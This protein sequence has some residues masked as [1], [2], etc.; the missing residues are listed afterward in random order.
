MKKIFS[1]PH[2]IPWFLFIFFTA[3]Y[4]SSTVGIMNSGDGPEYALTQALVEQHTTKID[5]FDRW[6]WPDYAEINGHKFI[7]RPPGI[8]FI[9]VPFY[10]LA[11]T[12]E[13][14]AFAPYNGSAPGIDTTSKIEALTMI[15]PALGASLTVVLLYL[16]CYQFTKDSKPSFTASVIFGLGTL[17]WKYSYSFIRQPIYIFLLILIYYL[18]SKLKN[19]QYP[20]WVYSLIGLLTGYSLLVETTTLFTLPIFFLVFIFIH[21]TKLRTAFERFIVLAEFLLGFFL[22]LSLLAAYNL[23]SYDQISRNLYQD[24]ERSKWMNY[25]SLFSTPL[26]PSILIN[27]F[28]NAPIPKHALSPILRSNEQ[29]FLQESA[30]WATR[31]PYKGLFFQSPFLFLATLGFVGFFRKYK[32]WALIAVSL[33]LSILIPL[34]KYVDF[35]SPNAYDTRFFL[36]LV[37]FLTIG[38]SFWLKDI[39]LWKNRL[40]ILVTIGVTVLSIYNGWL[41]NLTNYAPHVTGEHRFSFERL[42]QPVFTADHALKNLWLVFINTFPNI[43]NIHILFLFYFPV[44]FFL[45]LMFLRL[46]RYLIHRVISQV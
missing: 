13:P 37:P 5:Q 40:V 43:Y 9:A 25:S 8:S 18:L 21:A 22:A 10:I 46:K 16:I 17:Q 27:V 36:P 14:I 44:C 42:Q 1:H 31:Y 7:K 30:I 34:S 19:K 20:P 41:A 26:Y 12:L 28:S 35:Y 2:A 15:L 32:S 11:K 33:I 23:L 24:I 3:I 38:F 4:F 45:C 29:L 39:K 6:I